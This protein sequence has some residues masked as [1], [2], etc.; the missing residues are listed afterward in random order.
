MVRKTSKHPTDLELEVLNVLW[1]SGP[2][3]GQQIRDELEPGRTL[4]YQSVMT[5]LGIMEE[6]KYVSRKKQGSRFVYR[7]QI[8][9]KATSKKMLRDLVDRIFGGSSHAAMIGL[10]QSS[11]LDK[12]E[13]EELKA[14]IKRSQKK[15]K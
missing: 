1:E 2:I 7:A 15:G 13:L 9:Q 11:D 4:T 6:K 5:V 14:E 10:L 8:T 12:D 3:S